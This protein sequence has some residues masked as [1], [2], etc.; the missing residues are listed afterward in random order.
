MKDIH[1]RHGPGISS[2]MTKAGPIPRT[3]RKDTSP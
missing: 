1:E 2:W 3:Q